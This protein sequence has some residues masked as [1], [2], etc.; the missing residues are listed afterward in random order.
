MFSMKSL[1]KDYRAVVLGSSGGIGAAFLQL[2][3][4]D[5]RCAQ[6]IGLSRSTV[7]T[8]DL[9][10]EK[11]IAGAAQSIGGGMHLVIDATGF[12]SDDM[13]KP[14]KSLKSIEA[15]NLARLYE[16][17]AIGPT[18]IIKHFSQLLP[19][20]SR[21]IFATL[22]ARVGSIGDNGLGGW[23]AYRASKAALNMLMKCAAI[24][25]ARSNPMT[26]VAMLHPGTVATSLSEP[27]ASG[28]E[29]MT[30]VE[31]AA[32]MLGVLDELSAEESGSHW[33][34]RSKRIQW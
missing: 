6:V 27:F 2:L 16:L 26:L 22:S 13:T 21:A 10:D 15:E 4:A 9:T 25:I 20:D 34:Y 12:L 3:E 14:E 29:R 32:K 19:K 31:S 5:P 1:P 17:N 33:D 30:P 28:R 11:S 18:L 23:Y 7:P 24:E 8:F